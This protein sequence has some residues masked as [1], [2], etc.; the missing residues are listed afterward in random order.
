[1]L[2][3]IEL[4]AFTR[5]LEAVAAERAEDVL[6]QIQNNLLENPMRG[7]VVEGTGGVRKARAADPGRGKGKRGGFRYLYYFIER[8]GQIFLLMIFSKGDQDD[9]SKD[10]KRVLQKA[11]LEL[12]EA[13]NG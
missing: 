11:V 10:Q 6:L 3:F 1:V 9:L 5:R 12:R 13:N 4:P 8:A 2:E 7:K